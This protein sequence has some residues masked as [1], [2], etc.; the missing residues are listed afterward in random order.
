MRLAMAVAATVLLH[1]L[2]PQG[3]A[4][5]LNIERFART[6]FNF[7]P[8]G[9]R[10][11]GI[12]GAFTA[13]AD[14]ATAVE[15]N[16]AGLTTLLYPEASFEL[17]YATVRTVVSEQAGGG[18]DGRAF[19]N[20]GLAPSFFSV[21]FP[22]GG[23]TLAANYAK[24]VDTGGVLIGNGYE[25]SDGT[26]LYPW[27]SDMD[28]EVAN[29]GVGVA[30][31]FG[32][33]SMGVSGGISRMSLMLSHTRYEVNTN[34]PAYVVNTATVS[35]A[36]G[37]K[38]APY[39]NLGLIN[40]FGRLSA[41]VTYKM[42][43]RFEDVP[44]A[45]TNFRGV[46]FSAINGRTPDTTFT[47]KL[48]DALSIGLALQPTD[49]LTISAAVDQTLYSQLAER[50]GVLVSF[51]TDLASN[52]TADDGI[53]LR[54]GAEWIVATGSVPLAVRA[55]VASVAPANVY[56]TGSDQATQ[57][58]YGDEAGE[59]GIEFSGGFGGV[60]FNRIQFD[61][62]GVAGN[63]RKELITSFVLRRNQ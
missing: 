29:I 25:F 40:R 57:G 31:R 38:T 54:G 46:Q 11:M 36:D 9:A 60:L 32:T 19:N 30:K 33:L 56:Y 45:Y 20:G 24:I 12:G 4:A 7:T 15:S 63:Q 26:H 2:A 42:R 10:S 21:V 18:P 52:Y 1:A 17:K 22:V 37:Q 51:S 23:L 6:D 5:Q 47:V 62:A 58:L 35:E 39:V 34:Q 61:V 43:A 48:P 16:P 13:V 50:V 3:A 44:V 55:G 27:L 53:D 41:G 8:P 49:R 59:R 28:W 14:D